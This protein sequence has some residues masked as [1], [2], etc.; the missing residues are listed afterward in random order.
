MSSCCGYWHWWS[1][2]KWHPFLQ[3]VVSHG[4]FTSFHFA[5]LLQKLVGWLKGHVAC[6]NLLQI[7]VHPAAIPKN[8]HTQPF[9]GLLSWIPRVDQYQKKHSPTHTHPV[10]QASFI[11]FL[12]LLRS[13]A[14]SLFNFRASQYFSTISVQVLFTSMPH[15]LCNLPLIMNDTSLF[16]SNGTGCLNL[17]RP[18]RILASAAL[19]WHWFPH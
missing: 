18:V 6:K 19:H 10:R 14:S 3:E 11:H 13:I 9:N 17:F 2:C 12:R 8:T 15:V 4:G 7:S 1:L 16:I 5:C